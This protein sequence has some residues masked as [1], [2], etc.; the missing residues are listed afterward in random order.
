LPL[1]DLVIAA[2]A[3]RHSTMVFTTDPHFDLLTDLKR[4]AQ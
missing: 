3:E 4:F 1:S 2:A